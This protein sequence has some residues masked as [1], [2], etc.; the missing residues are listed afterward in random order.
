MESATSAAAAAAIAVA[1]PAAA[2]GGTFS[3]LATRLR[4]ALGSADASS[5]DAAV[6]AA[7][8]GIRFAPSEREWARYL[9]FSHRS[10]T[11]NLVAFERGFSVLLMCWEQGSGTGV[12]DHGNCGI[13]T[14]VRVLDGELDLLRFASLSDES[15]RLET[16]VL[17]NGCVRRMDDSVGAHRMVNHSGS[18]PAVSIHVYSPP[19]LQCCVTKAPVVFCHGAESVA[20]WPDRLKVQTANP[21]N[22]LYSNFG[23]LLQIL[24][25]E[26]DPLQPG[27][28]HSAEHVAHISKVLGSMSFNRKEWM[29]YAQFKPG[30]YTRSLVGF[31][32]KFAVMMLC[33]DS[34]QATPVH[35]HSGSSCWMKV[36]EGTLREECYAMPA[37][38]GALS[39]IW[40]K[41]VN[42]GDVDTSHIDDTVGVHKVSN[43]DPEH[44]V[45]SLHIYSPPYACCNAYDAQSGSKWQITEQT[46]NGP[47][48]SSPS[49]ASA[50]SAGNGLGLSKKRRR[51]GSAEPAEQL[52][53]DAAPL[54]LASFLAAIR[55]ETGN[56]RDGPDNAAI[57][58]SLQ[59]LSLT[60]EDW[61]Q[62][63]HFDELRYTR[64]LIAMEENFSVMIL[65]W[66]K[67]QGTP[68]HEHGVE[69]RSWAK[70]LDGELTMEKFSSRNVA[71]GGGQSRGPNVHETLNFGREECIV[72]DQFSGLHRLVNRS[73]GQTAV[74]LHV[75]SPPYVE[76][77]YNEQGMR[78]SIPAVH[79][80]APGIPA[81]PMSAAAA[82][83]L[84][85]RAS[86][87]RAAK[88]PAAVASAAE[89]AGAGAG[90][91]A[92]AGVDAGAGAAASPMGAIVLR[93]RLG[94][95]TADSQLRVQLRASAKIFTDLATYSNY[96]RAEFNPRDTTGTS[97][98]LRRF[99]FQ[100]GE[101]KQYNDSRSS[102]NQSLIAW[103]EHFAVVLTYWPPGHTSKPHHHC[104]SKCWIKVLE[105][106]LAETEYTLA[107]SPR[108]GEAQQAD[109]TQLEVSQ[110]STLQEDTVIY[111]G[112][113]TVHRMLNPGFDAVC[114]LHVYSPPCTSVFCFAASAD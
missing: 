84:A 79:R 32:P 66:D 51:S 48:S 4:A 83:E 30:C 38:G 75:F 77:C 102:S 34:R 41:D 47:P 37:G 55:A 29:Q 92:A 24:H 109:A 20:Q 93:Q 33:W 98:T 67:E 74:S 108:E 94:S 62:F 26:I 14:W 95:G 72:E 12:H 25:K 15:E 82:D 13:E 23:Q 86:E 104:G 17:V 63:V 40:A 70:V 81:P 68:I 101:W 50:S 21:T 28:S 69:V 54:D 10:Y 3:D 73:A 78:V 2:G 89:A 114:S 6:T 16:T 111:L 59:A 103:D 1:A 57:L 90:A 45:V 100:P 46:F 60:H 110:E 105:G 107:D 18:A 53:G 61:R 65:C 113:K 106:E 27:E 19:M 11:R 87:G 96:L 64:S 85:K 5:V 97:E 71:G 44:S 88:R 52:G 35:D 43:V 39:S 31:D 9:H 58:L 56:D 36:L 7:L 42:A 22:T 8:L 91:G 99:Q 80:V 112:G 49:A 76:C